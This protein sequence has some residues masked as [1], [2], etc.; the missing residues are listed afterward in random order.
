[1]IELLQST[2]YGAALIFGFRHGFDWDHI[3]ALTDLTGSQSSGRRSMLLATLYACGHGAVVI[4]LGLVA[5]VFAEQVPRSV[6]V[7]MERVVGVTLIALAVYITWAL[8]WY[9]GKPVFRSRWMV[10]LTALRRLV[11][12]MHRRPQPHVVIEHSHPHDHDHAMH[13][14]DHS[15]VRH[16]DG[17]GDTALRV[18]H[19]HAHRHVATMPSDPFMSYTPW[20]AL[21]IGGLHGVGAETPTQVLVFAAAA[22]ASGTIQSVGLLVCFAAGV[23]ASNTAVA[24]A[25]TIGFRGL[26]QRRSV[27]VTLSVVMAF[28]SLSVGIV[29]LLGQS[30]SLPPIIGG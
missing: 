18:R 28:L 7:V 25:S 5:I 30:G 16:Q 27:Y 21:G 19:A 17:S 4:V 12:R 20:A 14:H 8:V 23:L 26:V 29:F 10:V 6:D 1:M 3:A 24:V 15:R 13:R 11:S 22:G 2:V 9:Q